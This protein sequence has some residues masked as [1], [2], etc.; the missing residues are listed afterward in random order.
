MDDAVDVLSK[1]ANRSTD[2]ASRCLE[3]AQAVLC[4]SSYPFCFNNTSSQKI[5]KETC[6]LFR[7]GGTCAAVISASG[8]NSDIQGMVLSNC[9]HRMDSAGDFPECILVPFQEDVNGKK[10][11]DGYFTN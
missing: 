10:K 11:G 9:D 5:C 7:R 3:A 6:D 1:L 4:H 8:V 2:L